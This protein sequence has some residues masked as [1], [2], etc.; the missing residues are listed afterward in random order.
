MRFA[1]YPHVYTIFLQLAIDNSTKKEYSVLKQE[2]FKKR[3]TNVFYPF[4]RITRS[5]K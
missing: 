2:Q 4:C 5:A 3:V 1:D